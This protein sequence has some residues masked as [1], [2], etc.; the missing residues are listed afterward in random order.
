MSSQR[1]SGFI[2]CFGF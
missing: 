2:S 1:C